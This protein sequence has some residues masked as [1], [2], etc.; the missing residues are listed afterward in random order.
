[1]ADEYPQDEEQQLAE[2]KGAWVFNE[3]L[4]EM[5]CFPVLIAFITFLAV[6]ILFVV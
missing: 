2:D 1:M 4:R 3:P 5:G 6:F